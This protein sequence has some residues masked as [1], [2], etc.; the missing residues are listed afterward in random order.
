MMLVRVFIFLKVQ[1][2][3]V[4]ILYVYKCTRFKTVFRSYSHPLFWNGLSELYPAVRGRGGEAYGKVASIRSKLTLRVI[5]GVCCEGF[6]MAEVSL[7][8]EVLAL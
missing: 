5:A 4:R 8:E 6:C 1:E 7:L 2:I 3:S